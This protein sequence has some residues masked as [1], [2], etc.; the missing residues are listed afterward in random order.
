MSFILRRISTTKTGKQIIRDAALP[1]DTITL[2]REGSNTIHVA[3]LAVNP[4][5]ATISS[6]DGRHV[7][8]A[9]LEG[10]GFDLNGRSQTVAD[11]DSAAG[12][13]LRFGSHRPHIAREA[14][15]IILLSARTD[16][17]PPPSRPD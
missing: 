1:G 8:V 14:A 4:H 6:S 12:A 2:G 15:Q 11:L 9:A 13:E 16:E 3:D 17:L 5:H 10:L 7:R